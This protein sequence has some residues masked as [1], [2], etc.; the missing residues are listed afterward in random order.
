MVLRQNFVALTPPRWA[1]LAALGAAFVASSI[2]YS[3]SAPIYSFID[4]GD[5]V[6]PLWTAMAIGAFAG[7][8]VARAAGGP[9]GV[10]AF[11]AYLA[12]GAT[13]TIGGE[14]LY[15]RA[16]QGSNFYFIAVSAGQ[17]AL[18]QLPSAIA[19]LAGS[20]AGPRFA[21]MEHGTNAFLEAAGAYSL[22]SLLLVFVGGP[23]DPRLAPYNVFGPAP[24]HVALVAAQAIVAGVVFAWRWRGPLRPLALA[25]TFA[26]VGLVS[27]MPNDFTTLVGAI[28]FKWTEYWPLSLMFVPPGTALGV[29]AVVALGRARRIRMTTA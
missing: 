19:L 8:A 17:L 29:V 18:W 7:A 1:L 3:L 27:V 20:R 26:F 23:I 24:T 21:R 5:R 28:R 14:M 25:G 22:A 16:I 13:I 4:F 12:A 15:E 9:L 2:T 10:L 6:T 11:A